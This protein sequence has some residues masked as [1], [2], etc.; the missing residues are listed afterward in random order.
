MSDPAPSLAPQLAITPQTAPRTGSGSKSGDSGETAGFQPFGG[1]G[2]TF[3]DLIDVINPLQHIPIISSLYRNMTGDTLDPATNIAGGALFGGPIGAAVSFVNVLIDE[4]TGQDMGEHVMALFSDENGKDSE[5]AVAAEEPPE[6]SENAEVLKWAQ[7]ESGL[8]PAPVQTV[9]LP[10]LDGGLMAALTGAERELLMAEAERASTPAS[11][12]IEVLQWAQNETGTT[13]ENTL[14]HALHSPEPDQTT[15][16]PVM[17]GAELELLRAEAEAGMQTAQLPEPPTTHQASP[18]PGNME[19][20]QWAQRE[21]THQI[22][23]T[24]PQPAKEN[25]RPEALSAGAVA[26]Q[27]GWFSEVMLSALSGYQQGAKL[28]FASP[29]HNIDIKD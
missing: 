13:I 26:A 3:L 6:L 5:I 24:V 11:E 25:A 28:A 18:V 4:A 19:V 21:A 7:G 16:S 12:H 22:T 27:G 2:L 15:E 20:A 14:G 29:S 1:D 23:E 10:P 9:E 8:M 17:T